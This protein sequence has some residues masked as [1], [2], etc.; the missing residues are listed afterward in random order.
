MF[1]VCVNVDLKLFIFDNIVLVICVVVV[2]LFVVKVLSEVELVLKLF[3]YFENMM[4][5]VFC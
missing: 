3:S 1:I 5:F 4:M 2:L